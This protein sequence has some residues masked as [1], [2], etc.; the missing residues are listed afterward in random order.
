[1][2]E[3]FATAGDARQVA[4][5]SAHTLPGI[6]AASTS[7]SKIPASRQHRRRGTA[8]SRETG[9]MHPSFP[10][11]QSGKSVRPHVED[12]QAILGVM[13][14]GWRLIVVSIA[15][16]LTAAAIHASR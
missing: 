3:L 4:M 13:R 1:M 10:K 7:L 2:I 11:Q 6:R 15:V 9:A 16:C 5:P 8:V 14:R 12:A